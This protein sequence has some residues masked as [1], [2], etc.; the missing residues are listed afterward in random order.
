VLWTVKERYIDRRECIGQPV[1]KNGC[2]IGEYWRVEAGGWDTQRTGKWSF[3]YTTR[4]AQHYGKIPPNCSST[5][6][7][8]RVYCG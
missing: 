7:E 4:P 2:E 6:L 1:P 3:I 5:D 8:Y